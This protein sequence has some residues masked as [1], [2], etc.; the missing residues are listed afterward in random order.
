MQRMAHRIV[1]ALPHWQLGTLLVVFFGG[2][3]TGCR[4]ER[5]RERPPAP[6]A[7]ML[8]AGG[9]ENMLAVVQSSSR[10][11]SIGVLAQAVA[12]WKSLEQI[13]DQLFSPNHPLVGHQKLTEEIQETTFAALGTALAEGDFGLLEDWL[14]RDC[15]TLALS[16]TDWEAVFA[17]DPVQLDRSRPVSLTA[18]GAAGFIAEWTAYAGQF[19]TI[20]RAVFQVTDAVRYRQDGLLGSRVEVNI[21]VSGKSPGGHLQQ[22]QGILR[23]RCVRR[24]G[25]WLVASMDE[26]N[27]SRRRS[28]RVLFVDRTSDVGLSN[29]YEPNAQGRNGISVCDFDGDGWEDLFVAS[30]QSPQLFRN[31]GVAKFMAVTTEAGFGQLSGIKSSLWFDME[32]DGDEDVVFSSSRGLLLFLNRGNGTFQYSSGGYPGVT[33]S[34]AAVDYNRDGFL[35]VVAG[36]DCS[37]PGSRERA[38]SKSGIRLYQN[39]GGRAFRDVTR[40]AGLEVAE[41][42][43]VLA[44]LCQD[45]NDDGWPDIFAACHMNS[46]NLFFE[47]RRDGT[48][49]ECAGRYDLSGEGASMCATAGDCD[50]DGRIDIFFS[51]MRQRSRIRI[52]SLLN[53][54]GWNLPLQAAYCA[55]V[56][57]FE[58]PLL[59]EFRTLWDRPLGNHLCAAT[60]SG[61]FSQR[62]LQAGVSNSG[63]AWGGEIFDFDNDGH[64]DIY[65]VNGNVT[66]TRPSDI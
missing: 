25:R 57:P 21:D 4:S 22:D 6:A 66:G 39:L 27:L 7:N 14:E 31:T 10:E 20:D 65:A 53:R 26:M 18:H 46:P 43:C 50:G 3:W 30:E 24:E 44:V 17:E 58:I 64:L 2:L 1:A 12:G 56:V 5:P 13:S 35:D 52:A 36:L 51:G 9:A 63:M 37:G 42:R 29:F 40:E 16:R 19:G 54:C 15:Q 45:F 33:T 32:G 61:R 47:S 11:R 38:S 48:F 34:L 8:S 55:G 41:P 60:S 62:G 49:Q 28:S 23:A 59:P